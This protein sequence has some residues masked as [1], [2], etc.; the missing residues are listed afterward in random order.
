MH[1]KI[2][3]CCQ[4]FYL[5]WELTLK[6]VSLAA[7]NVCRWFKF[8]NFLRLSARGRTW[9]EK[10]MSRRTRFAYFPFVSAGILKYRSS[11]TFVLVWILQLYCVENVSI[12]K[13]FFNG[14]IVSFIKS[15]RWHTLYDYGQELSHADRVISCRH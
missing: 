9:R 15:H 4:F 10:C 6:R 11:V 12:S 5:H 13:K 1:Y 2:V 7:Q 8:R 14:S 3:F